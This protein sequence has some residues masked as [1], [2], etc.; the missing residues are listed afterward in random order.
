VFFTA[1]TCKAIGD[2]DR[3]DLLLLEDSVDALEEILV[4]VE[5]GQDDAPCPVNHLLMD[6]AVPPLIAFFYENF[7]S[8]D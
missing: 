7:F 6:A 3:P 4:L 5:M 2:D 1:Y 8:G